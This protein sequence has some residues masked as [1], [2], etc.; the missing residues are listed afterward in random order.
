MIDPESGYYEISHLDLATFL[1]MN[2]IWPDEIFYK[3]GSPH[4]WHR[5]LI[6]PPDDLLDEWN[7]LANPIRGCIDIY[8]YIKRVS[9]GVKHTH[10]GEPVPFELPLLGGGG[11]N[12]EPNRLSYHPIAGD[13]CAGCGFRTH[14][15]SQADRV[16]PVTD[17]NTSITHIADPDSNGRV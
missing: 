16:I 3:K 11:T 9:Y 10:R 13:R 6:P 8:N 14:E 2:G 5:Y 15:R 4:Y 17:A 7:N 1:A 12:N